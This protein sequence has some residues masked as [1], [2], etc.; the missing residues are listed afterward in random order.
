MVYRVQ[1]RREVVVPEPEAEGGD[2]VEH[3]TEAGS[4]EMG[5]MGR[6]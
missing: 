4:D 6:Q 3:P 1:R 5:E 2:K